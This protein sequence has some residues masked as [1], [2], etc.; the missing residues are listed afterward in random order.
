MRC[1]NSPNCTSSQHGTGFW[2]NVGR[3]RCGRG[4]SRFR[5]PARLA[6]GGRRGE[7]QRKRATGV[8][9]LP[10]P[11]S[12]RRQRALW[13]TLQRGP[14]LLGHRGYG[15]RGIGGRRP[16]PQEAGIV[17]NRSLRKARGPGAGSRH[18][19]TTVGGG[20][21][22]LGTREARHRYRSRPGARGLSHM[23]NGNPEGGVQSGL[24]LEEKG[25]GSAVDPVTVSRIVGMPPWHLRPGLEGVPFA[26]QPGLKR[27]VPSRS[28]LDARISHHGQSCGKVGPAKFREAGQ[29][30]Q[31]GRQGK[32][33]HRVEVILHQRQLG[34]MSCHPSLYIG[35]PSPAKSR[36]GLRNDGKCSCH[37]GGRPRPHGNGRV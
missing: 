27:K 8:K 35:H 9:R 29:L 10:A 21:G 32:T 2:T 23:F 37:S 20:Q 19:S 14:E 13:D 3:R 1:R 18:P 28:P 22:P 6:S 26:L 31:K 33:P 24:R 11:I 25:Q 15:P 30:A 36:S 5:L 12:L 34:D 17:A 7:S 4:R 16:L